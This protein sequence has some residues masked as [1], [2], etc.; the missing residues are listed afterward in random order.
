MSMEGRCSEL[1]ADATEWHPGGEE[2]DIIEVAEPSL[3]N[4]YAFSSGEDGQMYAT[5]KVTGVTYGYNSATGL[6]YML[7]VDED[8]IGEDDEANLA[9]VENAIDE[10]LFDE[11]FAPA[12]LTQ[13]EKNRSLF[14]LE[15]I[16][17]GR[18]TLD[19][20]GNLVDFDGEIADDDA[21]FDMSRFEH[22]GNAY[23]HDGYGVFGSLSV[24]PDAVNPIAGALENA[25][26]APSIPYSHDGYG[27]LGSVLQS[28]ASSA[29]SIPASTPPL[30]ARKL[31]S[32]ASEFVPSTASVT[33]A[34]ATSGGSYASWSV[35][36]AK[37]TSSVAGAT[38][39]QTFWSYSSTSVPVAASPAYVPPV[40]SVP[41]TLGAGSSKT[42]S[43]AGWTL[44]KK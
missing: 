32:G 39:S 11:V 28:G 22:D 23:F 10:A 18:V 19:D 12:H 44:P 36:A 13:D 37:P 30:P 29:L 1:N 4:S 3:M 6:M 26:I 25:S 41:A 27:V 8:V 7:G 31:N 5:D 17:Q 43:Y 42:T 15:A 21:V 34:P 16:H 24:A 14:D 38:A 33:D 2:P 9:E 40:A 35:G 20:E